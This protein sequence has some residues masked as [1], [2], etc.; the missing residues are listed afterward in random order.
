[1]SNWHCIILVLLQIALIKI[2]G[3]L[4]REN[5]SALSSSPLLLLFLPPA[6]SLVAEQCSS[7]WLCITGRPWCHVSASPVVCPPRGIKCPTCWQKVSCLAKRKGRACSSGLSSSADKCLCA[8]RAQPW[9]L[10]WRGRYPYCFHK[11]MKLCFLQVCDLHLVVRSK[12]KLHSF[13][14][15]G[16]SF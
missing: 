10:I 2:G 9:Q 16:W 7:F 3:L 15:W 1:M 8:N 5:R 14:P 11:L 12:L 4:V 13:P 6:C